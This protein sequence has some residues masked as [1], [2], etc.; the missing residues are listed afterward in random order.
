MEEFSHVIEALS[1][2]LKKSSVI[3]VHKPFV[4]EHVEN[5]FVMPLHGTLYYGMERAAVKPGEVLLVPGGQKVPVFF[6]SPVT[7]HTVDL[8]A[9]SQDAELVE[10]YSSLADQ[11]TID[12]YILLQIEAEVLNTINLFMALDIVPFVIRGSQTIVQMVQAL[13]KESFS[14]EIGNHVMLECKSRELLVL[15]MRYIIKNQLFVQQVALNGSHFK[16]ERLITLFKYINENLS[17]DLS[18]R[19]LARV[20]SVSDDYI[21]QYFKTL[22]GINPQDY[23]E[24]QRMQRAIKILRGTSRSVRAISQEVGYRDSSY[25]CRRFKMMFGVSAGHMRRRSP[26]LVSS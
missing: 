12:T 15:I 7:K 22:T 25:F 24:F 16:D 5:A 26:R 17:G 20:V 1:L 6:S 4:I 10:E 19:R 18:N 3:G 21:G 13:T 2:R 23:I 8:H 11:Y 9:P 14:T